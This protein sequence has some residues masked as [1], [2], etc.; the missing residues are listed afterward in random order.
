MLKCA[1][2]LGAVSARV[3][4]KV[5]REKAGTDMTHAQAQTMLGHLSKFYGE[6]VLPLSAYRVALERLAAGV[7]DEYTPDGRVAGERIEVGDLIVDA[8]TREVR[9]G[10][11][12][13]TLRPREF[14]MLFV[15][16]RN[17]DMVMRRDMLLERVW[18]LDYDGDIRTVDVHIRRVRRALG[19]YGRRYLRTHHGV[20]YQLREPERPAL[21]AVA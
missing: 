2:S 13:L 15:L 18:G 8:G 19:D 16:A 5:Q 1:K 4:L 3:T 10:E 20:G 9:F 7:T 6:P 12:V 11:R 14:D 21:R 17:R